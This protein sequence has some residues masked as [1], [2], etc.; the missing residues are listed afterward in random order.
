[1]FLIDTNIVSEFMRPAP[2]ERVVNWVRGLDAN[3]AFLSA[4]SLGEILLGIDLLPAGRRKAALAAKTG[5][6]IEALF[7]SRILAFDAQAAAA[8]ARIVGDAS[9]RGISIS[10]AD[11][12]IAATASVHG[13]T[14]ATRDTKPFL[15]A[16]L[17][18]INPFSE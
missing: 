15:A 4:V 12:Q 18:V 8:F 17:N 11:G 10:K 5:A 13:F 14:V 3:S 9:R 1:M 6:R 7:Q 16:G 2:S